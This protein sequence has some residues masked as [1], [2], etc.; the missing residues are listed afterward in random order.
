MTQTLTKFPEFHV[1]TDT[2][3]LPGKKC[4][5]DWAVIVPLLSIIG[6]DTA[7]ERAKAVEVAKDN[8]INPDLL[9]VSED[10]WDRVTKAT[11]AYQLLMTA[12]E[13]ARDRRNDLQAGSRLASHAIVALNWL[14]KIEDDSELDGNFE[15]SKEM[16]LAASSEDA[17]D[18]VGRLI[19]WLCDHFATKKPRKST[20]GF[21]N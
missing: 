15:T 13:V 18:G 19:D 7:K 10:E 5:I 1:G 3:N 12:A 11:T 6:T 4:R 8:G 21:G 14:P 9:D 16:L 20:K 17:L 2:H